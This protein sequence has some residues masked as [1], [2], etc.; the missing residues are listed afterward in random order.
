MHGCRAICRYPFVAF[1]RVFTVDIVISGIGRGTTDVSGVDTHSKLCHLCLDF[2]ST[3]HLAFGLALS[4]HVAT[5]AH[6]TLEQA[7]SCN[8]RTA[9]TLPVPLPRTRQ[10]RTPGPRTTAIPCHHG[11]TEVVRG[12]G[13]E[14]TRPRGARCTALARLWHRDRR[15]RRRALDER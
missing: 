8:Q 2:I 12:G 6:L 15:S 4:R 3:A 1:S 11:T 7:C 5:T 13:G 10:G 9:P 14:W